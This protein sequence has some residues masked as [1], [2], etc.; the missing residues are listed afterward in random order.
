M[1]R[2]GWWTRRP[3]SRQG[4][5]ACSAMEGLGGS[6][7]MAR[8]WYKDM[9]REVRN[10][11]EWSGGAA[12]CWEPRGEIGAKAIGVGAWTSHGG[13]G[14]QGHTRNRYR[15]VPGMGLGF[16]NALTN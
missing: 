12:E 11:S 15:G 1:R 10:K 7:A 13:D 16:C 6:S 9:G 4:G 8:V 14:S 5:G 2:E 3:G